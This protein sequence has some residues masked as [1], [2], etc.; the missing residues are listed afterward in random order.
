MD[1]E[2]DK[3]QR[4]ETCV[5]PFHSIEEFQESSIALNRDD[6]DIPNFY[7]LDPPPQPKGFDTFEKVASTVLCRRIPVHFVA[8]RN[9]DKRDSQ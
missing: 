5:V 9:I 3:L 8:K 7:F 1:E 6:L 2:K 4:F